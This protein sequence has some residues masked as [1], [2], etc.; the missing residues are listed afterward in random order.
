[1][2]G[3]VMS[4]VPASAPR[5]ARSLIL[6]YLTTI[7]TA[8]ALAA[9]VLWL[10]PRL[11]S[12][13]DGQP[14]RHVEAAHTMLHVLLALAV[15]IVTARL[16][17]AVFHYLHQPPVIGEVVGGVLLGPSLFGALFPS[18]Y[19]ALLPAQAAPFLG[20]ISQLGVVLYMFI[21]GLHLDLRVLRSSGHA[22]LAISH[23]SILLPFVLGLT[24]A[25]GLYGLA[26]EGSSFT[27][28]A[29]FLGASMSI[30]AF[31]VLA[32]ILT[33]KD[34]HRT[35]LGMLALT[36][37]AVDD[38]TAWCLL[39]FV[40]SVARASL[41]DAFF[42]LAL[43]MAYIA[44]MLIVVRPIITRAMPLLEKVERLNEGG[45]AIIFVALLT[46][47]VATEFIGIH[48]IFG[49]FLLGA[50]IPHSSRVT[51]DVTERLD[52]LV[53]VMF[54]PAFFAFTGMR[55]QIGLLAG[56]HDW[57]VCAG[58]VAVASAGKF[59]GTFAAAR[60]TGLNTLDSAALG[61]LM[62]T[63]GLVELIALNIGLDIGVFSPRIFTM[64]V[65]MALVTTLVTT[66]ILDAL[67]RGRS[68]A[69]MPAAATGEASP[70]G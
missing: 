47:A 59:G 8:F 3:D 10:G 30:T 55:T 6:A 69:L 70:A 18:A 45:L 63:R 32:R 14:P 23:T 9:A 48:A 43:T 17:G 34:L 56:W 15:V 64:L 1:M 60:Y 16:L 24:L 35:E 39:A 44:I 33:D 58:I 7:F 41:A 51:A 4:S 2:R 36:C 67:M 40:V 31:P 49:A 61:V 27:S 46:S 21:V 52:A 25:L 53:R 5:T 12:T 65:I 13:S 28:F 37:A 50:V 66:P 38:V 20:V 11:L 54:L 22:A 19:A 68:W 29:L 42:T 62:N 26:G 57:L